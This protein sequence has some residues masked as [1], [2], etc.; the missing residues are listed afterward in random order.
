MGLNDEGAAD[1]EAIAKQDTGLSDSTSS[2]QD[3]RSTLGS[4]ST[5]FGGQTD[6]IQYL[7]R[8]SAAQYVREQWGLPC[9]A[10]WL[11]KL[12]VT[13]GGP[14]FRKCGRFPIYV[15][16]DLD[17]WAASRLSPPMRSTSDME[18]DNK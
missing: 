11:A 1:C 3:T 14:I 5:V 9:E 2:K 7:R 4:G 17:D 10:S 6:T 13:G 15:I 12:A 18:A 8:K 16:K